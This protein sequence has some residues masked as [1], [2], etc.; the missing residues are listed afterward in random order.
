MSKSQLP[1]P[2]SRLLASD[3]LVAGW[4]ARALA[5]AKLTTAVRRL[6]PRALAERV[7][8]A[9]ATDGSLTLAA[10][11]GT[12][13]AVV[14]QRLPEILGELKREGCNFTE[15]RVRVQV[16]ADAPKPGKPLK[17]Q[18]ER[19]DPAPL[20]RLA[21]KL[22]DGALKEAVQRLARRI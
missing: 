16:R 5:E 10:G 20:R 13:A 22:P 3:P 4:L 21:D 11:S 7:H 17:I 1:Q 9:D 14:R 19:V 12:I 6:L 8:V 2:L 15:I 18:R